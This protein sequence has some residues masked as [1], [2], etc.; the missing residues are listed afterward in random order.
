[1]APT[2]NWAKEERIVEISWEQV[3]QNNFSL[4]VYRKSFNRTYLTANILLSLSFWAGYACIRH[5]DSK[6][7]LACI[8][9]AVDGKRE[10]FH[11]TR[12]NFWDE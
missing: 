2:K 6:Y 9:I 4:C 12:K 1:M 10:T 5:I 7:V 8:G 11:T 3:N